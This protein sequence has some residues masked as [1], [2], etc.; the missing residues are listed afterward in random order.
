MDE[1]KKEYDSHYDV[2]L[3]WL[4][5]YHRLKKYFG[6][7]G[8]SHV[9]AYEDPDLHKWCLMCRPM[10]NKKH[11]N[12]AQ[13]KLLS[14]VGFAFSSEEYIWNRKYENIKIGHDEKIWCSRQ[15]AAQKKGQLS[16]DKIA[17]LNAIGFSWK[18]I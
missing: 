7:H 10:G 13:I 18:K 5:N 16:Q 12:T 9:G 2:P 15:R 1:L 4:E 11:L 8:H 3:D 17:K 6:I 14:A